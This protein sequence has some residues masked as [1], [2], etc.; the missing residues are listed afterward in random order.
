MTDQPR[1][2]KCPFVIQVCGRDVTVRR[3]PLKD[4]YGESTAW[5]G[6]V[7]IN[8]AGEYAVPPARFWEVLTHELTHLALAYSGHVDEDNS[9]TLTSAQE[10]A[11]CIVA[12]S[13]WLSLNQ[14]LAV[15]SRPK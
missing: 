7:V 2:P 6:E 12:E 14:A 10:E 13:V 8:N 5:A 15:P 9:A 3:A 4:S 11:V 1:V